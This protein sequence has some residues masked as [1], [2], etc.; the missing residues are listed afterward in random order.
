MLIKAAGL[1]VLAAISRLFLAGRKP[2]SKSND[3]AQRG[4]AIM[5]WRG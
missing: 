5:A 1:A 4:K 3:P 2:R